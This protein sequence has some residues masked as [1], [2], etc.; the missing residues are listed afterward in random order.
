MQQQ[1]QYLN[2]WM[3]SKLRG[4]NHPTEMI[5]KNTK[6]KTNNTNQIKQTQQTTKT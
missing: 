5:L 2:V 3:H 4:K 6:P 1:Q